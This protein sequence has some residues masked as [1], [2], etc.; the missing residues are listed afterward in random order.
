MEEEI[1]LTSLDAEGMKKINSMWKIQMVSVHTSIPVFS[2][3]YMVGY[4]SSDPS[5]KGI[6]LPN[7]LEP[8]SPFSVGGG[9]GLV[10]V[11]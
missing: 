9:Y 8:Y 6:G 11:V 3:R 4:E 2:N 10:I 7:M 5:S 1:M